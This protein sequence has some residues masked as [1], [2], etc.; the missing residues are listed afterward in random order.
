MYWHPTRYASNTST[1]NAKGGTIIMDYATLIDSLRWTFLNQDRFLFD[2]HVPEFQQDGKFLG[3]YFNQLAVEPLGEKPPRFYHSFSPFD[4]ISNKA[5]HQAV[6][7]EAGELL[8][9]I[10]FDEYVTLRT[11]AM[12]TLLLNALKI[13]D[14]A[15][16]RIL[17][18]GAGKLATAAVKILASQCNVSAI[19]IV[20]RSGDLT[21][22]KQATAELGVEITAGDSNAIEMYD[23]I[24][25]H[26]QSTAPVLTNE[27]RQKIKQGALVASFITSTEHGELAD[28]FYNAKD[29]NIV[30][31][32]DKT[33]DNAKDMQRAQKRGLF[34]S[35][36]LIHL[37]DLLDSSKSIDQG[38]RYTIY[39]STG[40][41]IQNL[42]ILRS[43][44]DP[45]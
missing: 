30:V 25:C 6:V 36:Q 14:L 4:V 22:I 39:R 38:K 45:S 2:K 37:R 27:H 8:L 18:F 21:S 19:D 42:A 7:Y 10:E 11:S 43:L 3:D 29:A 32:W 35:D 28:E 34:T 16:K 26:T 15:G 1:G 13:K 23:F 40:T 12:T 41:P 24:I 17:M 5:P 44:I 31:D 9:N 20:T 33:I